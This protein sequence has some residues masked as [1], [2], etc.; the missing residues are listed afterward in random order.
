MVCLSQNSSQKK[1]FANRM[2]R[3]LLEWDVSRFPIIESLEI[4]LDMLEKI[5][6]LFRYLIRTT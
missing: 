3:G 4:G 5:V 6:I 1:S 2:C